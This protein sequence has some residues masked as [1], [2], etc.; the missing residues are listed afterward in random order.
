MQHRPS[1]DRLHVALS[2]AAEFRA[3]KLSVGL[4]RRQA[5]AGHA[6]ARDCEDPAATPCPARRSRTSSR[7]R[8]HLPVRFHE[9][10]DDE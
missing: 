10:L 5:F 2:A 3:A 4:M 1:D 7:G 8:G 9:H 6:A